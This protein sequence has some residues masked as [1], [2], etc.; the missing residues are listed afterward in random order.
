M[1]KEFRFPTIIGIIFLIIAIISGVYLTGRQTTLG[2]KASGSCYPD[3][4]QISNI[5]N[6]AVDISFSTSA[7]CQITLS[8]NNQIFTDL[9]PSQK[10]HYFE[11]EN[12]KELTEYSFSLIS[13]GNTI[14]EDSFKFTTATTP[15][16]SI[17]TSKIAWGKV[18]GPDG[19]TPAN[20]VVYLNIP[21]AA[22]LSSVVTTDGNWSIS[23]A[24]SFNESKKDWFSVPDPDVDEEIIVVSNDG[25]T[26]QITNSTANN[27]PV[28]DITVGKN[29]LEAPIVNNSQSGFLN[30]SPVMAQKNLDITNPKNG[31]IISANKPNFFGVAPVNSKIIIEVHS[32]V[33]IS[34]EAYS[35]TS[36]DWNWTPPSGL[37]PGEHTITVKV[38]NPNTGLWESI[39]RNF[40][41]SAAESSTGPQFV[42]SSS[43]TIAPPTP[44]IT[45][46]ITPTNTA[47][48]TERVSRPS[49][50]VKP[51]VTG[52]SAPT[53]IIIIASLIFF[54]ISVKFI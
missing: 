1:K 2:S 48:P 17:P 49:T 19:K 46:T 44:T 5:T 41:V 25:T 42:A 10:L 54:L 38:Q 45:S 15:A 53:V 52:N 6:H 35:N 13:E 28:P 31:E 9:K 7:T 37:S 51:P 24:N 33:A 4:L 16:S 29:I 26:T 8:V 21:G 36:G 3:I 50:T 14:I 18:Y 27:N 47:V 43:A 12:L 40:V 23:L 32:D 30:V 39:V 22:P 34:G 20:A 11:I